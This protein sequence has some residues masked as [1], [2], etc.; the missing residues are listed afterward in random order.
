MRCDERKVLNVYS[1]QLAQ[2]AAYSLR[3]A[4]SCEQCYYKPTA[5]TKMVEQT[6]SI[7]AAQEKATEHWIAA[8]L[9]L[10]PMMKNSRE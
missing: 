2:V 3:T 10:R 6:A 4:S 1:H 5:I 8:V 7:Q 9:T